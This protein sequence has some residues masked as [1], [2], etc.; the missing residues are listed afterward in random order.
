MLQ[1]FRETSRFPSSPQELSL[2]LLS[3]PNP[4][5]LEES[6]GGRLWFPGLEPSRDGGGARYQSLDSAAGKRDQREKLGPLLG[7][8]CVPLYPKRPWD[9]CQLQ[10]DTQHRGWGTSWEYGPRGYIQPPHKTSKV[11][12]GTGSRQWC[13][14]VAG[15]NGTE[16]GWTN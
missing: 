14:R 15:V 8:V 2:Q 16:W 13:Q 10:K 5:S 12:I 4:R 7:L 6:P 3:Q 11:K 9:L 1:T